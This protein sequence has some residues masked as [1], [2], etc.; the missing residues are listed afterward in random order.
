DDARGRGA[1]DPARAWRAPDRAALVRGRRSARRRGRTPLMFLPPRTRDR[2]HL[3]ATA[4][5]AVGVPLG[6][7]AW[8]GAQTEAL[9]VRLGTALLVDGGT[10][11]RAAWG[12][13]R[14]EAPAVGLGT[15]SGVPVRVGAVDADLTGS[16]RLSDVAFGDLV[17]AGA[18]EAS[19]ALESLLAGQLRADE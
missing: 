3:I 11:R 8:V 2:W 6:A 10:A 13:A 17:A 5:F 19:V 18:I 12:G 9:A 7:A 1:R 14:A 16:V 15:A 4:L